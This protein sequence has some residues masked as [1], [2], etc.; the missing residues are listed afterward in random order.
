MMKSGK[1]GWLEV[2]IEN[3][4]V[5]YWHMYEGKEGALSGV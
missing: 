2:G 1:T 4:S 3:G 5:S